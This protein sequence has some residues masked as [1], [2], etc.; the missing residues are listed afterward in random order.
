MTRDFHYYGEGDDEDARRD[1]GQGELPFEHGAA[2]VAVQT[3][4]GEYGELVAVV[5]EAGL[6]FLRSTRG[7]LTRP[8]L[9][10]TQFFLF[11][12]PTARRTQWGMDGAE[13]AWA[14]IA[15]VHPAPISRIAPYLGPE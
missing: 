15:R 14:A 12:K 3:H 13:A 4:R 1:G 5:P 6:L 9:P 7:M 10:E 2:G 11:G 8:I